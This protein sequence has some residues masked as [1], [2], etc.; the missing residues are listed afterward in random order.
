VSGL[1]E[2][3]GRVLSLDSDVFG[4]VAAD[5]LA[6]GQAVLVVVGVALAQGVGAGLG[7]SGAQLFVGVADACLRWS[8]WSI[9]IFLSAR[10]LGVPAELGALFR[11]LG[12][13]AAP[14]ALGLL[15]AI[16]WL[17]A[18]FWVAKWVL[19]VSAFVL[20]VR[21]VLA[22]ETGQALALCAIGLAVAA[23]LAAPLGWLH[24][25]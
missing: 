20:A 4:E 14:L 9:A 10:A 13:A 25:G 3:L 16:P 1:A 23:L 24:P 17:G 19:G 8:L 7:D 2:R 12:F 5:T 21:R 6:T 15:E 11:A 22:V 18:F